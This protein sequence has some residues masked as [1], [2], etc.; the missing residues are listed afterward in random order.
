MGTPLL[1]VTAADGDTGQNARITYSVTGGDPYSV[2][3]V[4]TQVKYSAIN[5]KQ[6]EKTRLKNSYSIMLQHA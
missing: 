6:L 3:T 1:N 4:I 2:F 5:T